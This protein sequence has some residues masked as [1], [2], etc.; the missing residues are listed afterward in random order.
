MSYPL[1]ILPKEEIEKKTRK[2]GFRF[3]IYRVAVS[4]FNRGKTEPEIIRYLQLNHGQ[5]EDTAKEYLHT[6]FDMLSE[7]QR[8]PLQ[9]R[10]GR[11][12][13]SL[14]DM[15]SDAWSNYEDARSTSEKIRW[16]DYIL[17]TEKQLA[18][19]EGTNIHT[20][21]EDEDP[22]VYINISEVSDDE[23]MKSMRQVAESAGKAELLTEMLKDRNRK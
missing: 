21:N 1:S 2:K 10:R 4:L 8:R 6:M 11:A 13:N 5:S 3:K 12:V 16:F 22:N 20:V 15:L 9:I 19:I 7:E 18:E 23:V 17:R 14:R